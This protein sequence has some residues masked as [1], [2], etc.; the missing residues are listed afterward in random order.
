M[1]LSVMRRFRAMRRA[2]SF[3]LSSVF[4]GGNE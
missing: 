1:N 4:V 3:E 2:A